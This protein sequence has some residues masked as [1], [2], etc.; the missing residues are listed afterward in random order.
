MTDNSNFLDKIGNK[1]PFTT[2]EGYFDGLTDRIMSQLP[3]RNVESPKIIPLWDRV[4]PWM[5]MAAM[6]TGIALMINLF[7]HIH[8][9][10]TDLNLSSE[11]DIEDFYQYYE[12]EIAT[13][14]YHK[15]FYVDLD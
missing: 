1:N 6:F 2:P 9:K 15:A 7:T 4:K 14:A 3:E 8:P 10:N 12:D 13:A 5:Y 11:T